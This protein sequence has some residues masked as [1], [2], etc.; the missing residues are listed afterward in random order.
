MLTV[1]QFGAFCLPISS[2]KINF[3]YYLVWVCNLV[4]HF[5]G[6]TQRMFLN[7]VLRRKSGPKRE[8]VVGGCMSFITGLMKFYQAT[9][10]GRWL[11]GE[12]TNVSVP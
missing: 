10:K 3:T 11:K 8:D 12:K 4:S 1:V 9:S 2:L 5:K 6:R 7:R